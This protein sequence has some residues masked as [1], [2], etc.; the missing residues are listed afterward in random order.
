MKSR[1]QLITEVWAD[2]AFAIDVGHLQ[3]LG[4]ELQPFKGLDEYGGARFLIFLPMKAPAFWAWGTQTFSVVVSEY[5]VGNRTQLG[6]SASVVEIAPLRY[7][8][9]LYDSPSDPS[10]TSGFLHPMLMGDQV[11]RFTYPQ[12]MA[13]FHRWIINFTMFIQSLDE[14]GGECSVR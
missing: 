11:V 2:L 8:G 6:E 1:L 10:P 4:L 13:D 7:G 5:T 14:N 9:A 3:H 12:R